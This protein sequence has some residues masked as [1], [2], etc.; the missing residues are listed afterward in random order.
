MN[1]DPIFSRYQE[2]LLSIRTKLHEIGR[3]LD[4]VL[5]I[6]VSKT[7]SVA[8]ML[9]MLEAAHGVGCPVTFGENY[10]QEYKTKRSQ[11][12]SAL[13][14]H[15]IGHLQRNKARDAVR[16]FSVI[17]SVDSV[18]LLH[19]IQKEAAKEG[20]V[21]DIFVQVNISNDPSKGG[22]PPELVASVIAAELPKA[23]NLRIC[24]LM[25]ITAL[26]DNPEDAR[27]DFRALRTLR[28]KLLESPE[29]TLA[30]GSSTLGLSMGMSSD[31]LIAIEEGATVVRVGSAIFGDRA[32][33]RV[34]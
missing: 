18:Q 33:D 30:L 10:I 14:C 15:F 32:G 31:Y 19:A 16:M 27:P 28:D 3:P 13:E 8:T 34:G 4:S 5:L 29:V 7:H 20:K 24:G 6:A 9:R 22:V 21:Q 25:T 12:P 17:E 2:V 11:L 26:Y 23:P 1:N